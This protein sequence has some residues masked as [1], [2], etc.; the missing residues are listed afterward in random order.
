MWFFDDKKWIPVI[1]DLAIQILLAVCTTYLC[2]AEFSDL[3][4]TKSKNRCFSRMLRI[5]FVTFA[6]SLRIVCCVLSLRDVSPWLMIG[7]RVTAGPRSCLV[8]HS[9]AT[10]L[11]CSFSSGEN[12]GSPCSE[13]CGDRDG[14]SVS[15]RQKVF[16]PLQ[17]KAAPHHKA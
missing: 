13:H 3:I 1:S 6:E 14:W 11:R 16:A 15:E 8:P 2:Y 4:N 17:H 7:P 5:S 10:E 12:R 9:L